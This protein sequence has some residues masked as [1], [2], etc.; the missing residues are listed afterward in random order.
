M[1]SALPWLTLALLLASS[2]Q[3]LRMLL[4]IPV[5][6]P[7]D[8]NEGWNALQVQSM[9]AG[10]P[11]YPGVQTLFDNN[12]PPGSFLITALVTVVLPD[13]LIAGRVVAVASFFAVCALAGVAVRNLG[14]TRAAAW[15]AGAW[16]VPLFMAYSHYPGINDPQMLGHAVS[17]LG[18]VALLRCPTVRRSVMTAAALMALAGFVKHNLVVLPLATFVWLLLEERRAA[19]WFALAGGLSAGVLWALCEAVYDPAFLA[20]LLAPREY[21]WAEGWRAG[22][23]WLTKGWPPLAVLAYGAWRQRRQDP[24]LRFCAIYAFTGAFSGLYFVG[25][26]GVDQNVFF[27]T[28]IACAIGLG[29]LAGHWAAQPGQ[30]QPAPVPTA[31]LLA[32]FV[33]PVAI[34]AA[35]QFDGAWLAPAHW[36]APRQAEA[37]HTARI[38][39]F[40]RSR[41]GPAL[42]AEPAYCLW[43]GKGRVVDPFMYRQGTITGHLDTKPVYARIHA[44]AFSVIQG[45]AGNDDHGWGRPLIDEARKSGYRLV[46][47]PTLDDVMELP[48]QPGWPP[49]I[50]PQPA[51]AMRAPR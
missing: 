15:L 14:G 5:I 21:S 25:G 42:C 4:S 31:W 38:V 7:L 33:L 12:Y 43:A 28:Y 10:L 36:F 11:L 32:G 22:A 34:S 8:F 29:C 46:A 51:A 26:A 18:L 44:H 37:A 24:A 20:H 30:N 48:D 9:L 49:G 3:V 47:E 41:P 50:A 35:V 19:G 17:L 39:A 40:L 13:P 27:D 6:A 23:H 16:L 2:P 45:V 1:R